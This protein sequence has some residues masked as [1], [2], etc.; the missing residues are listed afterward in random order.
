MRYPPASGELAP[1]DVLPHK[2][3]QDAIGIED[4]LCQKSPMLRKQA[5]GA[6][7]G[8]GSLGNLLAGNLVATVN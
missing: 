5:R 1:H 6:L 2:P 7:L 3:A 8:Q 4:V